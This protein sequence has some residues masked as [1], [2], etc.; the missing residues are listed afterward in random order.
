MFETTSA[1][2]L[3]IVDDEWAQMRALCDTLGEQGYEPQGFTS[4]TQALAALATQPC[5]LLLTDLMMPQMDGIALLRAALEI[6]SDLVAVLMTGE[7]TITTAVQAMQSGALDYIV[8]PFKVSAILPVIERALSVRRLRLEK[9][10]LERSVRERTTELEQ[11]NKELEA[12]AHSVAHDLRNPLNAI[13]G[14]SSLLADP[15]SSLS[16]NRSRHFAANIR[17]AGVHMGVLID[18]LLR[19]SQISRCA[20]QRSDVDLSAM[21]CEI[22]EKLRTDAPERQ[23]AVEIEPGIHADGDEGLLHIALDNLLGNAWKYTGRCADARIKFGTEAA[24]PGRVFAVRDNGAGFNMAQAQQ[25][26]EPFHRLHTE[27]DFPGTGIGLSIV[28]RIIQRHGGRI[29]VDA[30]VGQGACF[31]FT[32]GPA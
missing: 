28:H 22:L 12:F 4:P 20:M 32:L 17:T 14:F 3:M 5:D 1:A 15:R 30:T 24:E 16:E 27:A 9:A 23:V 13:I 18:D 26:F 8:K 11:A 10:A 7:G 29:G 25:L 19:L 31:Q 2:R 6:D 21:A